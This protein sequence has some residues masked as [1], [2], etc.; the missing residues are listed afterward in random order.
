VQWTEAVFYWFSVADFAVQRFIS[1]LSVAYWLEIAG[2][3]C[4]SSI[5]RLDIN[6][7]EDLL[8]FAELLID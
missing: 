3:F 4:D 2:L 7:A 1:L 5:P 8:R 6:P